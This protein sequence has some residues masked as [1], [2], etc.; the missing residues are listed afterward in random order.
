[1]ASAGAILGITV[2]FVGHPEEQ[3]VWPNWHSAQRS[4]DGSVVHEELMFHH[5]ELFVSAYSQIRCA[6]SD[7]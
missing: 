1:M 5:L 2:T 7:D 4:G 6:D 3:G